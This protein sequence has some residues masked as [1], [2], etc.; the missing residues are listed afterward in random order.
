MIQMI[1]TPLVKA[2]GQGWNAQ[3]MR[4]IDAHQLSPDRWLA[5]VHAGRRASQP[6]SY[7]SKTANTG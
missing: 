3:A 4:H 5:A 6:A 2:A 1:E 7:S